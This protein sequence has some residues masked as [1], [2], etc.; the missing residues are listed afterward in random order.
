MSYVGDNAIETH[1]EQVLGTDHNFVMTESD[2][3]D[4]EGITLSFM[5]KRRLSDLDPSALLTL[6]GASI[7]V[8]GSVV[9]VSVT[10]EDLDGRD[11][12]NY[13][14]ELKRLDADQN[15][16]L[17]R[18]KFRIKRGVHRAFAT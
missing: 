17:G 16:V 6:T 2:G 9:T 1:L 10:A 15:T 5:V 4:L 13:F 3:A 8:T 11:P 18:G 7:D 14:W 12:G